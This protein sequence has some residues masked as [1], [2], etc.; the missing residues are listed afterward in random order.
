MFKV[1]S[2]MLVMAVFSP[3]VVVAQSSATLNGVVADPSGA[4]IPNAPITVINKATGFT[5]S[6]T[7]DA[8]GRF[9]FAALPVGNY[10]VKLAAAGFA[11]YEN[12]AV[13]L[14]VGET[15]EL[16]IAL[17]INLQQSLE[18][19]E[20]MA[21][22]ELTSATM[23]QVIPEQQIV[24]LPL[25]GRSWVQ[26]G[27]LSPG[28]AQFTSFNK[29]Q[30]GYEP[31]GIRINVNGSRD[32]SNR[33]LWD[34]VNAND[35]INRTP[36]GVSGQNL[37]VDAIREFKILTGSYGAE[38]GGASGGI[39]TAVT[40]AGTNNWHGTAFE[41]LR[42]NH[43][44][45]RNYFSAPGSV[46]QF[47]RN[48]F[49]GSIGGPIIKNRTFIFGSYEGFRERLQSPQ[50]ALVP[51]LAA[52]GG[53]LP[54]GPVTI[55]PA[56]VPFL[57]SPLFPVP[58]GEE[59]GGGFARYNFTASQPID[60]N[61]YLV[62]FDHQLTAKNNLFARYTITDSKGLTP[63]EGVPSISIDQQI[64]NQYLT[65]QDQYL[66]SERWVGTFR[67]NLNRTRTI[68]RNLADFTV[69]D[70]M[71]VLPGESAGVPPSMA[72]GTGVEYGTSRA[73]PLSFTQNQFGGRADFI[74]SR[75]KHTLKFGTNLE[76][77]QYNVFV[78]SRKSGQF[79]F[80]GLRSFLEGK[81]QVGLVFAA[82][83][84]TPASVSN[85]YYRNF[86]SESYAQ[87]DLRL[88]SN[89]T[90]NLG[91]RYEPTSVP[92]EI[93]NNAV[94]FNQF[95]P[96]D[97]TNFLI[98]ER[99]VSTPFENQNLKNFAPRVGLAWD[100]F[101][102][103]KTSVRAGFGMYYDPL[104]FWYGLNY[105][106][107]AGVVLTVPAPPFPQLLSGSGP[108]PPPFL[109]NL[110]RDLKTPYVS[111]WSL[112]IQR[113]LP[114]GLKLTSGYVGAKGTHINHFYVANS[115]IPDVLPDGRLF[116]PAG[117]PRRSPTV[118]VALGIA[119][120]GSSWYQGWQTQVDKSMQHGL[121]F[122][123][124]Y[125]LSKT[126]DIKSAMISA[127]S[128]LGDAGETSN[129]FDPY[130]D[131]GRAAYDARHLIV[132][133]V[134]YAPTFFAKETG[135]KGALLDGWQVSGI[136]N[137]RSGLPF[138]PGIVGDWS[139]IGPLLGGTSRPNW[140][141]GR[142][143]ENTVLGGPT[144][145][146]DA[147]AFVLQTQG[148]FGNVGRNVLTG[149][150][151]STLDISLAKRNKLAFLGEAG[152][153]QFRIEAFNVLN[154]TNFELPNRFV[155]GGSSP[156]ETPSAIAGRITRTTTPNRQLQLGVKISF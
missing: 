116:F 123:F 148:T 10:S 128:T 129:P 72:F 7:T 136:T 21:G 152:N 31:G 131:K 81:P 108:T 52:R 67:F 35:I 56:I 14:T 61:F 146:F 64:R 24:E 105:V 93:N 156:T 102:D 33:F 85:H 89:L 20:T 111:R 145:Y 135:I 127:D 137:F 95:N 48:Q 92:K 44:D 77:Y 113:E 45:A 114:W 151:L 47:K 37:G 46:N 119:S 68:G 2:L 69:P 143:P 59:F 91:L 118:G 88:F 139:R 12:K 3:A 58:N 155:F 6:A 73:L 27:V 142:S 30:V 153:V 78:E 28:V 79:N 115:P 11:P 49:G 70:S 122:H 87:Y 107:S 132:A 99:G 17:S 140:A 40:R 22:V 94:R 141:P 130:Q 125:T 101:K 65:I 53:T 15:L 39:L 134:T 98:P 36:G 84:V 29:S 38:F 66:F 90:V 26:L 126:L 9:S 8:N 117:R 63:K 76:R 103:G 112:D 150:Q 62:R 86:Y 50:V 60:E 109:S 51:N 97:F 25:N 74:Y 82:D 133:N 55:A 1:I 83:R 104:L 43:L 18:V 32:Q 13:N 121:N 41:F 4:V 5:R 80:T 16:P 54:D 23:G 96:A 75:G 19:T 149:P 154:H 42:N 124:A 71:Q 110:A 34:G 120:T 147:T 100:P 106:V 57:N 144:R 138:T